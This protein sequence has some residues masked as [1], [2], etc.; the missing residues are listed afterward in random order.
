M[1][2]VAIPAWNTH[3]V[4]PPINE[5]LPTAAERSPYTVS[6]TDFVLRFSQSVERRNVLEG[7]L[8]YRAALHSVGLVQGFQWL[9]GSFLEHVEI[10]E[11]R[12]PN[13][14][15]VVTFFELPAGKTQLDL[16]QQSPDLFPMTRAAQLTLKN[17]YLVDAYLE[18]LRKE[19][20]RL[21]RQSSY[22][23]SMWSHR[24]NKVWK[25]YVQIDLAPTDDAAALAEL[26]NLALQGV[27]P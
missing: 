8:R 16:H 14:I 21:V 7:F 3:G 27:Q 26:A 23:Y 24:R 5:L 1:P 12:T 19:P 4:I 9:D 17:T 22:W 25:G 6:L 15:D 13:D 11:N 2:T 18:H 20:A 10:I